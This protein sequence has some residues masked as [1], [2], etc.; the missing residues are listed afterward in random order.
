MCKLRSNAKIPFIYKRLIVSF[1]WGGYVEQTRV[2]GTE[3][4]YVCR[5]KHCTVWRHLPQPKHFAFL[6]SFVKPNLPW[7]Y[8]CLPFEFQ[9]SLGVLPCGNGCDPFSWEDHTNHQKHTSSF[10]LYHCFYSIATVYPLGMFTCTAV[11]NV[12]FHLMTLLPHG[13]NISGKC[14]QCLTDITSHTSVHLNY[15]WLTPFCNKSLNISLLPSVHL[16]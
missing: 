4:C 16:A 5:Q 14:W 11:Q 8:P 9:I 10:L 7:K 6:V 12:S 13:F 3:I 15:I 1:T 2:A